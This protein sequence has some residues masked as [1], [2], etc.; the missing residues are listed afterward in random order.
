MR[1]SFLIISIL[2]FLAAAALA[3]EPAAILEYFDDTSGELRVVTHQGEEWYSDTLDFGMEIP[4]GST[5]VTFDDDYAEIRLDPNGSIIRISENTNFT[6][7]AVQGASGAAENVFSVA[8]GKFRAVA[9]RATGDERYIYKGPSAVCGVRGTD[10]G[11][12][13]IPGELESAFVFEGS[14]EFTNALGESVVLGAGMIADAMADVF[15]AAQMTSAMM[16]DLMSGLEFEKLD[17]ASVPGHEPAEV[18]DS[19]EGEEEPEEVAE[20]DG[21]LF[22]K[23]LELL[24]VEIGS[25][26]IEEKTWAK[27]IIQPRFVFG[28]WK[29]ALYLPIIYE[30]DMLDP[31][32]WYKPEGNDEWSFGHDQSEWDEIALDFLED[33][34]LKIRYIEYG[35]QRDPFFFKVGN[36][37]NITIGHGM[38]MRNYANDADFPS[39][40]KIGINLGLDGEKGGFEAMVNDVRDVTNIDVFGA[41]LYARPIGRS[42]PLAVGISGVADINPGEHWQDFPDL[43][44]GNFGKPFLISGGLDLDFPVLENDLLSIILFADVAAMLPYFQEAVPGPG[45]SIPVGFA[46]D[47]I[48][49]DTE[50]KFKNWGFASGFLGNVLIVDYRLEGRYFTG[51]FTPAIYNSVYDRRRHEYVQDVVLYLKNQDNPAFDTKTLGIY[52]EATANLGKKF[53]LGAGYLWPWYLDGTGV[54]AG[55]DDYFLFK[56]GVL[57][58]GIPFTDIFGSLTYERT[59]FIQTLKGEES[60]ELFDANTVFTAELVYPVSPILNVAALVAT[61][62]IEDAFGNLES[63]LTVSIVT[64]VNY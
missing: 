18:P 27:A 26:T 44:Y 33:L 64:R 31:S 9:G 37:N 28:K 10:S 55:P 20:D 16:Q 47:A 5:I 12:S 25:V 7:D 4:I 23:L 21:G 22:G 58:G 14:I 62:V 2:F 17:K 39:V 57:K 45:P 8:V 49:D 32:D 48:W 51:T 19:G 60:L 13:V 29:M 1:K 24:G 56:A 50:Q 43:T 42:F 54:S 40:R 36:L 35:E 3:G 30:S 52:G 15:A 34:F 46:F 59:R 11:M 63:H 41:R 38:I 6:I 53:Y 61:N